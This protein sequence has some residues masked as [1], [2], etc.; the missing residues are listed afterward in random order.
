MGKEGEKMGTRKGTGL[1]LE[2]DMSD[3]WGGRRINADMFSGHEC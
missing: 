2:L 1:G 3:P